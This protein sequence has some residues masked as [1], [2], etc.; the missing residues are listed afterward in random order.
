MTIVGTRARNEPAVFSRLFIWV[1]IVHAT[2]ERVG[3]I[4]LGIT[5]TRTRAKGQDFAVALA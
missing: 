4:L 1:D 3:L 2:G 5:P